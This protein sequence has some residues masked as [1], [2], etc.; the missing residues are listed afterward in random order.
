MPRKRPDRDDNCL[1]VMVPR[2]DKRLV[3][4]PPER[5]EQL[6]K[7]L[8]AA[9]L[10]LGKA[11]R[12][13]RVAAPV[14]PEPAGLPAV[15]ARAACSLCRGWCC[16]NGGD[17]AFLDERALARLRLSNPE[18]TDQAIMR[19][20]LARVPEAVYQDS[21]IFHGERGC[22]LDR[23]MRADI[24]NTYLCGGLSAYMRGK[25]APEP[26]VVLA[27]EGDNRRSPSVLTPRF[28]PPPVQR[29]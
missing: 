7:H 28:L 5:V 9:L 20:Y 17:E 29:P 26:T 15:V 2:S 14:S 10:D 24:C 23:S 16:R 13:D 12:L 22:T 8:R 3:P 18:I 27:G 4:L 19:I 1:P 11:R 25:I 6:R 21:C